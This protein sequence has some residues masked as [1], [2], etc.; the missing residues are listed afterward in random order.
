M[1]LNLYIGH[2]MVHNLVH[3]FVIFAVLKIFAVY[4]CNNL[5]VYHVL[6]SSPRTH[7]ICDMNLNLYMGHAMMHNLGVLYDV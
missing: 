7:K 6:E 2:A 4:C 5:V 1:N 3:S